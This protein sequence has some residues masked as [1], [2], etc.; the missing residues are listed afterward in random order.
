VERASCPWDMGGTPMPRF[1]SVR[2]RLADKPTPEPIFHLR[3]GP[4]WARITFIYTLFGGFFAVGMT[5]LRPFGSQPGSPSEVR[6]LSRTWE[7]ANIHE[8]IGF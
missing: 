1:E 4:I 5:T 8:K 3:A 7:G 6:I 2:R